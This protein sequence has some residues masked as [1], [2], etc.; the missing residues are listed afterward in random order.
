MS[1]DYNKSDTFCMLPWIHLCVRPDE[2]LKP[3][4][5]YQTKD[6]PVNVNLD[7]LKTNGISE[8]NN[9][10]LKNL[11]QDMLDG[12][13]RLE[14]T[15][16]YIQEQNNELTDRASLRKF[17]NWRFSPYLKDN[18]T[19]EFDSVRYIEMSLDNICNLQC[20]MCDSKFSSKLQ[21]RDKFLEED[22][23]KK[24]E[25][26]FDKFDNVD[27]SNLVYIKLLGG[28]P[29]ISPNFIKFLDYIE[30]RSNPS[31]IQLEIATNGTIIPNNKII[32]KLNKYKMLYINVSLDAYDK[33]NDYQ[34]F[35]SSYKQTYKNAKKYEK[36]FKNIHVSFHCA[37]SL[38]TANKL[39]ESLNFLMVK[40][41]YHVS[42]DFVRYPKYLSLLYAPQSYTDWLLEINNN[43]KT[44]SKL[45]NTFTKSGKYNEK[46]WLEFIHITKKLDKFYGTNINDY[47]SELVT[48]LRENGYGI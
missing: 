20:K 2:T 34:R 40:N 9:D 3:C 6:D 19:N 1:T 38:L 8:M 43:N 39:S 42:V 35:G 28:E 41:K 7:A 16:C 27:L 25:P 47:N 46:Y 5:R 44:A 32:D 21:L 31:E 12:V 23:F 33:A 14:C 17:L 13:K 30:N 29:F 26:S 15:K 10:Y 11:R 24:L 37:V 48:Y 45:V 36:I 4:C 18:Y 22:V